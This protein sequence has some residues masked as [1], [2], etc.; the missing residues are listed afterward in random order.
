MLN[1]VTI[2]GRLV[3]NPELR[4]SRDN[5]PFCTFTIANDPDFQRDHA[6]FYDMIAFGK[7]AQFIVDYFTKGRMIL[8]KGSLSTSKWTDRNGAKRTDVKIS[9]E[10]AY[11]CDSKPATQTE[12][13]PSD[14]NFTVPTPDI[15]DCP[16]TE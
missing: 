7:T 13:Q 1:S 3:A 9:V 14:S 16:F 8:I 5:T 11:F 15:D 4:F 6:D 2:Q 12:N 10:H